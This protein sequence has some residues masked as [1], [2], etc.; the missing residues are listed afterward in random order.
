MTADARCT[1][2]RAH[3][4]RHHLSFVVE[5]PD[6]HPEEFSMQPSPAEYE[7]LAEH[8]VDADDSL[9]VGWVPAAYDDGWTVD[10]DGLEA[11]SR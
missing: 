1:E 5:H 10:W 7:R 11:Y 3:N 8:S 6:S 2:H 4:G 9:R